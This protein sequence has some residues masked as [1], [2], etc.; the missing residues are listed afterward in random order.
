[1][2]INDKASSTSDIRAFRRP[3]LWRAFG[4]IF[5][6]GIGMGGGFNVGG[7]ATGIDTNNLI[8]QL[9]Q[10]ER[11]PILRLQSRIKALEAQKDSIAELRTQFLS[12]RNLIKD[13]QFGLDFNKFEALSSN[14]SVLVAEQTGSNPTSGSFLVDVVQLASAT[15]ATSSAELG[16]PIN[17]GA[18]LA[19]SGITSGITAGTFSIN[20]VQFTIDPAVDSLTGIL[21]TINASGAG[22][23][24]TYDGVTDTVTFENS[25]PGDTSIVNFGAS[26]DTSSFLTGIKVVGATQST[27]GSG[28]TIVSSKGNLG[29]VNPGTL[30]N[31]AS[32]ANGAVT[33]GSFAINGVSIAIDP[34][35]DSISDVIDR[36]NASDAGVTASYD[37]ATDAIRVVSDTLGSRTIS[38]ASGTSNFLDITNLTAAIQTAGSDSQFTVNGGPLQTQNT[39]DVADAISGVTLQLLS[40]GT[41]SVT[42]NVDDDSIIES[43]QKFVDT[44]NESIGALQELIGKGGELENDSSL[45]TIE[46]FLKSQVFQQVPGLGVGLESLLDIGISTGDSFD[47]ASKYQLSLD[48]D[49]LRA[50]I[51]DNREGVQSLFSNAAETGIADQLFDY[52][53]GIT[54]STGFLNDRS[55][56]N[57]SIDRQIDTLDDRIE[58]TE[59]R[60]AQREARLRRQFLLM[61]TMVSSLQAQGASLVGLVGGFGAF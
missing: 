33:A 9:M 44:F 47:A 60:V 7:L 13:L 40:V 8:A 57:G 17:P 42:V 12:F 61:E 22:V 50:V 27:G 1:M 24:A 25:T 38:F 4:E 15:V 39:N 54:S 2:P 59:R 19:S 55:R 45:R 29:A 37:T 36:I 46:S 58:S 30:L 28:S 5:T 20:G 26:G 10:L 18:T 56:S 23:T 11:R 3:R 21:N 16:G 53:D 14:D 31:A 34:A 6:G 52:M 41:S 35:A 49:E 32:F 48:V 43:I 51:L